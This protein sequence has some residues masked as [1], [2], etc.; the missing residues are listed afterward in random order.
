MSRAAVL[1]AFALLAGGCGEEKKLTEVATRIEP[2][3]RGCNYAGAFIDDLP[4]YSCL[5]VTAGGRMPVAR[6][7][8]QSLAG[9]G[10]DVSCEPGSDEVNVQGIGRGISASATVVPSGPVYD[11]E[12]LPMSRTD[13]PTIPS[14]SVAVHLSI[15]PHERTSL[16][17]H[18]ARGRVPCDSPAAEPLTL[19]DCVGAW[20]AGGAEFRHEVAVR[21]PR[22]L[23]R[24]GEFRD[25]RGRGCSFMFHAGSRWV[26]VVGR[27]RGRTLVWSPPGVETGEWSPDLERYERP[28]TAVLPDGRLRLRTRR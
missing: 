28:N 17:D 3:P 14:G 4:R 5:Y 25:E 23:A 9:Q 26:S 7:I 19:P 21:R 27:W 11:A 24:V 10:L 22:R 15:T 6:A 18:L 2:T 1:F 8:A 13:Q 20:N 16:D 12:G